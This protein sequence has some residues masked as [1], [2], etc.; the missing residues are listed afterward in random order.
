MDVKGYLRLYEDSLRHS[1]L[2]QEERKEELAMI[3]GLRSKINGTDD[4]KLQQSLDKLTITAL[5]IKED[6]KA[7]RLR[8]EILT[9][10]EDVPGIKGEILHLRYIDFTK[11]ENIEHKIYLSGRR[12]RGIHKEALEE[13][14][15]VLISKG[16]DI[17]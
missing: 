9:I 10:I 4:L 1:L 15:S 17:D 2:I 5:K 11:W 14:R 13:L 7:V 3:K 8:E 6:P 16:I 12:I